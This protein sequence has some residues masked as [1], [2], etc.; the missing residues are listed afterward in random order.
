MQ[1]SQAELEEFFVE[2]Q[3]S[4]NILLTAQQTEDLAIV[5]DRGTTNIAQ[6]VQE[7]LRHCE[8]QVN[9]IVNEAENVNNKFISGE[10]IAKEEFD[11]FGIFYKTLKVMEVK[12]EICRNRVE[13]AIKT[14]ETTLSNK[15][16][17]IKQ[18]S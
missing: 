1:R 12:F 9:K 18:A 7:T 4:Y 13:A 3:K 14:I 15:L 10:D 5:K 8:I 11:R 2:I 17:A 6:L 16:L